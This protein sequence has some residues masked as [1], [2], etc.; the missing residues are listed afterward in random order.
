MNISMIISEG[1]YGVI[2]ADDYAFHGYYN[3]T[4]FTSPYTLQ[5][6]LSI[7]DQAI[8]FGEMVHEG[9]FSININFHYYV[10]KKKLNKCI[11]K[12]NNQWQCL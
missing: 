6:D 5:A 12:D 11:S 4:F 1:N 8:S 7:Y 9:F 10:C 3:I 2:Y